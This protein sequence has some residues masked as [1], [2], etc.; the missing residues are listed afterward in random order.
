MI[1]L[2]FVFI[3]MVIILHPPIA[4]WIGLRKN[5]MMMLARAADVPAMGVV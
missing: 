3:V 2:L 1:V 4:I 5:V